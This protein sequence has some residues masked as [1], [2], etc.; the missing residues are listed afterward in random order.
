MATSIS[1]NKQSVSEL[2][3]TGRSQL[4]VIPE[5]Q[6][7]YA[8]TTDQ[9]DTLFDDIWEFSTTR[10]GTENDETYFL[11]TVVAYDN[12]NQQEIIDGQQRITSLFLLLRAVY[13]KLVSGDDADSDEAQNFIR[14]IEPAIWMQDRRTGKV[15]Y[16]SSLL[17]S[18]VVDNEGNDILCHILETG[19]AD[20]K[21]TDNYSVNYRRFQELYDNQCV[22]SPLKVYDFIYALLNQCILMPITADSQ[23]T[24]LTIF[25]TLNN[26]GLPLSDADIFKAKIYDHLGEEEKLSFIA[27]WKTLDKEAT[28]AQ[29]S[30]QALFYYYM[31]YLRAKENDVNSSVPGVRR[32][33]T[34]SKDRKTKNELLYAPEL[35]EN[36][37][38]I[39]NIWKVINTRQDIP[40]EDWD[41]NPKI[42]KALDT[43]V[44]YPNEFW[45]YPVII[46]YMCHR[47]MENFNE[48]FLAFLN[49]LEEELMTRFLLY[50]TINAVKADILKLN[51]KIISTPHPEFSF[52]Q[53]DRAKLPE[54]ICTP[55]RSIVRMLLLAH[56]YN[57]Q[58]TLLPDNWQIEHILPRKWQQ[59]FFVNVPDD[60]VSETVEHIGNKTA[61]ERKLN[62]IASNGYFGKKQN[63]YKQSKIEVTRL[64]ASSTDSDWSLGNIRKRD[65][66]I[67]NEITS[68]LTEWDRTY[69][70]MQKSCSGPQPSAEDLAKI[71]EFKRNGWV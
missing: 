35:M 6:R 67:I 48:L 55:H 66:I 47:K 20:E 3:Q 27:Q 2:L 28:E 63:E 59:T 43:L 32:Y 54:Q 10:G 49:K 8:W 51:A 60:E 33:F 58:D 19:K 69:T 57:H 18:K 39:L 52:R 14:Q 56:A 11:G 1:V 22:Q 24:A 29:E 71:E 61:F 44:A 9:I 13:T 16:S 5:Y 34:V 26:R 62:I 68:L 45:K 7:P 38:T 25:S 4:F 46:Y 42:L 53:I 30:I 17:I 50:P 65:E 36:L 37:R 21:A 64:L 15:N 41:N 23:D 40:G 31:F 70:Q 12:N